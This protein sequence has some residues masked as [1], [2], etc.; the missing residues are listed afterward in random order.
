MPTSE[1]LP[2]LRPLDVVQTE[3]PDGEAYFVLHDQSQ[4]APRPLAV[5]IA[6]YV[7]LSHLDG[8]HTCADIVRLYREK[9]GVN[10]PAEQ[11][12]KLVAALDGGLFL[13]TPRFETARREFRMAYVAAAERDN[14][15]R[16]SA[17][18][19]LGAELERIIASGT[20]AELDD[21]WGIV[22]PHLDYA[23]GAPCYADAYATLAAALPADR[24]VLLGTNHA[25]WD[26]GVVATTKPFRTPLGL[27]PVDVA[28]VD[29]LAERL[30]CEICADEADHAVEHSIELQ[31]HF[32]QVLLGERPFEIVPILCPSPESCDEAG[33][34]RVQ[35]LTKL[36]AALRELAAMGDRRTVFIAGADLSHVG[37]RFGDEVEADRAFL[38][39]I[40]AVDRSYLSALE[41]DHGDE[42]LAEFGTTQ[43]RTHVCS[44]GCIYVLRR[45]LEGTD[46]HLLRYHQAVDPEGLAHVTCAAAALA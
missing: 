30:D 19:E 20:A 34:N 35:D 23:R 46:F 2:A 26:A 40:E 3:G 8:Q 28:C 36:A 13:Q 32:L 21:V 39:M 43:N 10:M 27:A 37:P 38:A 29:T 15:E 33:V 42:F 5:S 14:R 16:Y 12:E 45:V 41:R 17:A 6:S 22:A 25:N 9:V 7:A 18:D 11:I 1:K 24:Y 4:I 31:V 44:A